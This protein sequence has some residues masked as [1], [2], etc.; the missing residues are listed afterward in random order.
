[1]QEYS[2]SFWTIETQTKWECI[3]SLF[4]GCGCKVCIQVC[5]DLLSKLINQLLWQTVLGREFLSQ[6]IG[7]RVL[8]DSDHVWLFTNDDLHVQA[9]SLTL[10]H[11]SVWTGTPH[12]IS[13]LIFEASTDLQIADLVVLSVDKSAIVTCIQVVKF[14]LQSLSHSLLWSLSHNW[15]VGTSKVN[16]MNLWS[17]FHLMDVLFKFDLVLVTIQLALLAL[18]LVVEFLPFVSRVADFTGCVIARLVSLPCRA[19]NARLESAFVVLWVF[20]IL[21]SLLILAFLLILAPTRHQVIAIVFTDVDFFLFFHLFENLLALA[22]DVW[23]AHVL[24]ILSI[25]WRQSF[26]LSFQSLHEYVIGAVG[27]ELLVSLVHFRHFKST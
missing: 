25:L 16:S 17:K 24:I 9:L 13:L 7:V 8:E 22:V 27:T 18:S 4:I 12:L 1:M 26:L 6:G 2:G 11:S 5:L 10:C 3:W 19:I 21:L 15:F 23:L 14:S 20:H